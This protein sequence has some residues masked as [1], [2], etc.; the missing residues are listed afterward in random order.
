MGAGIGLALTAPLLMVFREYLPLSHNIHEKLGDTAPKTDPGSLLLNWMMPKISA[1]SFYTRKSSRNWVGVGAILLA[2]VGVTSAPARRRFPVWPIL[3][4]VGLVAFQIYGG[5]LVAWTRFIP[6]W[7]QVLWPTFGTPVI[8]FG[9][10]ILAAVGVQVVLDA[11][12]DRRHLVMGLALVGAAVVLSLVTSTRTIQFTENV[13]L[14]GGWPL[15]IVVAAAIIGLLFMVQSQ[16]SGVIV[17][18]LVVVEIVLLAPHGFYLPR[19][20]PYPSYAWVSNLQDRTAVDQ[21][22]VF[23]ADGLLYPDTAGVYQLS[24]PRMLDALYVERYFRYLRTF[25][26]SGLDDRFTGTGPFESAPNVAANP[27]FD[28]LGVRYVIY[29]KDAGGAPPSW[30][31]GQYRAV[32]RDGAVIVYENTHAAPRAFVAHDVHRVGDVDAA[33]H[34]FTRGQHASFPDAT[35][36]VS[37]DPTRTAVVEAARGDVPA[38]S[39]CAADATSTARVVSRTPNF[40]KVV[41]ENSCPGLLVL[42]DQYYPG[43]SATVN[44]RDARIYATDVALRGVFVPTGDSTVEFHYRPSSFR[45]GI[46]VWVIAVLALLGLL[47]WVPLT[48]LDDRRKQRRRARKLGEH[49]GVA[50]E[51]AAAVGGPGP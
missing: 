22:R 49:A 34:F 14:F 10:A 41:V 25:V 18:A 45:V 50:A 23:S 28:L 3:V 21:S 39:S 6:V 38:T 8:A 48:R 35:V 11:Q 27:M 7:S 40:V 42:S 4:I 12:I 43:W 30:S 17:V 1:L 16:W 46:A 15:A 32:D 31:E 9:V 36:Q 44:G 5:G 47:L 37:V 51:G 13:N 20:D 26:A 29:N 33:L 19:D 2:V 24:D